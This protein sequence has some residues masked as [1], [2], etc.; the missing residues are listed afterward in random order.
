MK[1]LAKFFHRGGKRRIIKLFGIKFI[2][3][4]L[5]KVSLLRHF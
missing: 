5:A 3:K 1:I 2:T 4:F